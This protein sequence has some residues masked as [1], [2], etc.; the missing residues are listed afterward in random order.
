MFPEDAEGVQRRR[1]APS[2]CYQTLSY[3]EIEM[4][5]CDWLRRVTAVVGL[6]GMFLCVDAATAGGFPS[7]GTQNVLVLLVEFPAG[8]KKLCPDAALPCSAPKGL[9]SVGPPRHSAAEWSKI[10]NDV[11]TSYWKQTTY[12]QTD[13]QFT[14]LADPET[15]DGWWPAPHTWQDY[16]RNNNYFFLTPKLAGLPPTYP[17]PIDVAQSVVK[18]ICN[19][20]LAF[21]V[22]ATIPSYDRLLV[23]K[24][25][26]VFGGESNGND[27]PVKIPLPGTSLAPLS[28]TVTEASENTT[29]AAVAAVLHELGHQLGNLSHYGDC[30]TVFEPSSLNPTVPAGPIEC[31]G[32]GWDIMGTSP[33]FSQLSAYTRVSQGWIKPSTTQTF[34]LSVP[35]DASID[36]DPIEIPLAHGHTSVIRLAKTAASAP[37]FW[38]YY[39]ECREAIGG[40]T[41][42]PYATI[43][44]VHTLPDVGL[45]ITN[46]HES[47]YPAHH[48]ERALL[49]SDQINSATLKPGDVFTTREGL[50]IKFNDYVSRDQMRACNVTVVNTPAV[51]QAAIPVLQFMGN[52]SLDDPNQPGVSTS[53]SADIGLNQTL[54]ASAALVSGIPLSPVWAGH[55]NTVAVRVHNRT[56]AAAENVTVGVSVNQTALVTDDCGST[57]ANSEMIKMA[58]IAAHSSPV[59]NLTWTPQSS[60]SFSIR[61]SAIGP[62]NTIANSSAVAFQFHPAGGPGLTST[63]Q[64][65]E[66]AQCMMNE[67]YYILPAVQLPGWSVAITPEVLHLNPGTSTLVSIEVIPPANAAPG[68]HAEIPIAVMMEHQMLIDGNASMTAPLDTPG[69]HLMTVGSLTTVA[70]IVAGPGVIR[71]SVPQDV[72]MGA[73]VQITG[74]V[75]TAAASG[76]VTIEYRSPSGDTITHNVAIGNEGFF[77]DTFHPG[78]LGLWRVQAWWGGDN[79]HSPTE[80]V[81]SSL[82]VVPASS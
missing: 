58:T 35:F 2:W 11:A 78:Q 54:P 36:L 39:A 16:F 44:N 28:M 25:F 43:P 33:S 53:I 52:L 31:L 81:A 40:D 41:P 34:D 15:S 51:G 71:L 55:S 77:S 22:C 19:N 69:R 61:A 7:H 65:A 74:G 42:T 67:T 17:M 27:S 50:S 66:G 45:L 64:V 47:F 24:N 70:R 21:E 4:S 29:D 49:P 6:L 12:D 38:G 20:P 32:G 13:F 79:S 48:I 3:R 37:Q 18:T 73:P 5:M 57:P 68:S 62:A 72:A 46:V 59:T 82:L 14:V 8:E 23:V 10:L 30:S 75:T 80:S 1:C 26:H 76:Q 60:D 63:F 56:N 9:L